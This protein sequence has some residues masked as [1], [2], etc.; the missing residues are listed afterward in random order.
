MGVRELRLELL[1]HLVLSL[2]P[3]SFQLLS[4]ELVAVAPPHIMVGVVVLALVPA[5]KATLECAAL[6]TFD[7]ALAGQ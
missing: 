5:E 6:P 7:V 4:E 3:S 2:L 1:R